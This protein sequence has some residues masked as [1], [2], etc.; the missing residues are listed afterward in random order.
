MAWPF[1]PAQGGPMLEKFGSQSGYDGTFHHVPVISSTVTDE[2]KYYIADD[3]ETEAEFL[4]YLHNISPALTQDDL[5]QLAAL[6]P[7]PATDPG[8]PYAGSPNSTQYNRLAAALSDYAYIC[9]G[10]ETAYRAATAGV[11]TWKARF[12]TNNSFPAWQGIPHTADTKYAWNDPSVQHPDVG[13]VYSGYLTSFVATGDPNARRY[14]GSPEWPAYEPATGDE[15]SDGTPTPN[16]L[17]IRA[18]NQTKVEPDDIR[19]EACLYWRDPERAP[20]LNK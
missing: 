1:Q 16:Q 9:P 18:D 8:S 14:P 6:Y 17:L 10:Q 12:D 7:D 4:D 15:G 13:L 11:P 2:A 19:T 20:R 3:F 5:D